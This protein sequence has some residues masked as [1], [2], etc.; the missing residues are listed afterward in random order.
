MTTKADEC[1]H[2]N[3]TQI[4]S[5]NILNKTTTA[6]SLVEAPSLLRS[7]RQDLQFF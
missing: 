5:A 7:R 6:D 1:L 4:A 3:V 2:E